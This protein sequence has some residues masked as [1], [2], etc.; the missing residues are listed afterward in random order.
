VTTEPTDPKRWREQLHELAAR[1]V[2]MMAVDD[3]ELGP[4]YAEKFKD[5]YFQLVQM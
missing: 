5:K 1:I 2:Q 4:G 3:P